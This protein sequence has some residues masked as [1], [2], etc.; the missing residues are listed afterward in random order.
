[1]TSPHA[2][3]DL[4]LF[5]EEYIVSAAKALGALRVGGPMSDL[6]QALLA[7]HKNGSLAV[8]KSEIADLQQSIWHGDDP[9]GDAVLA[10]RSPSAKRLAGSIYTPPRIVT[11]M[12]AWVLEQ[13]P[14]R[15]VDAGCGSGRFVN[16]VARRSPPTTKIVAVD[17]DPLATIVT[18]AVLSV[19]NRNNAR[20]VNSDYTRLA[21]DQT[22][23]VTAFIANPPYIRHHQLTQETKAWAQVAGKQLNVTVS[24]LAGLHAYFFLATALLGKANDVGSFVTSAEWLDVNYGEVIR[25][26]LLDGLG[27]ESIHFLEPTVQPF[28]NTATTAAVTCF[29][30]GS[31]PSAIRL[32]RVKRIKE[33]DLRGGRP[34]ARERLSESRR[35]TPLIRAKS[36]IPPGYVELGELCRVHRGAVTGANAVWITEPNDPSLPER[37]QFPSVTKAR[38]L[39]AAG[40][41]LA[42]LDTLRRV[43]DLPEDLDELSTDERKLVEAFLRRAKNAGADTG[44][45]ARTRRAWWSIRLREP[46]P[47]L[48]TYMARRPPAFVLNNAGARHINIAH[49]LYPRVEL[50]ETMLERLTVSLRATIS[51]EH[52]RTY[53]GGLTK[54]EP[55]EMERIPVP[56]LPLLTSGA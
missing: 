54:F 15:I 1:M 49:G 42:S 17:T 23:G 30:I 44:Y 33:L 11:P 9:L 8:S 55:R 48:A 36:Q 34:V 32:R 16:V 6:E 27:G 31:R 7:R 20:V 38:E 24:G 21:L 26:L 28:D 47:I 43:I 51:T 37:C 3:L 12:V 46:A 50:T 25:N 53:A 40:P 29:R 19:L 13:D 5:G 18:R 35:W 2:Q 10:L 41:K 14:A 52:G 4:P 22:V 45:I 39:F 56:D